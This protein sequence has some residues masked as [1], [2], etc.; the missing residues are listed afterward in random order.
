MGSTALP[1]PSAK[2]HRDTVAERGF[3]PY[4]RASCDMLAMPPQAFLSRLIM[5][6]V[7]ASSLHIGEWQAM[8]HNAL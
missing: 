3:D 5:I 2:H 1:L 7:S 8:G 4:A 6:W